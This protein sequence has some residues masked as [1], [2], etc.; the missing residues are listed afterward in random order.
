MLLFAISKPSFFFVIHCSI[1]FVIVISLFLLVTVANIGT[2]D[3]VILI[4]YAVVVMVPI[5]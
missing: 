1:L 3:S 2:R 4:E 5:A